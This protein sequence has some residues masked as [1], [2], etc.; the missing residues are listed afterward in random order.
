MMRKKSARHDTIWSSSGYS[1]RVLCSDFVFVRLEAAREN[2]RTWS[3]ALSVCLSV[4]RSVGRAASKPADCLTRRVSALKQA[5][6]QAGR[7]SQEASEPKFGLDDAAA[8][9]AATDLNQA[10]VLEEFKDSIFVVPTSAVAVR[11]N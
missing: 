4:C 5:G 10:D 2:E 6:R 7:L 11:R 9:A 1:C 3:V 8:A